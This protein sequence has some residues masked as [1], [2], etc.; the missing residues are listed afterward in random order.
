MNY[1]SS[2]SANQD[3]SFF[4]SIE[5]RADTPWGA[6]YVLD[7]FN[8][9]RVRR[10]VLY[11]LNMPVLRGL[12]AKEESGFFEVS[13]ISAAEH[14]RRGNM[15]FDACLNDAIRRYKEI[16]HAGDLD[17]TRAENFL[18]ALEALNLRLRPQLYIMFNKFSVKVQINLDN[19]EFILD[20]D[21]DDTNSVFILSSRGG[22]F[23]VKECTL[24]KIEETLR[25][26]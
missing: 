25:S 22:S 23:I 7:E 8:H 6:L 17:I 21:Y 15:E 16:N 3:L 11:Y 9:I 14:W 1:F 20:Y 12:N 26:F 18:T 24:D 10:P 2:T 13:T 19:R 5:E 4:Y